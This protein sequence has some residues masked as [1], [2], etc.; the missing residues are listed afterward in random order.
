M[1]AFHQRTSIHHKTSL[2]GGPHGF[3]DPGYMYNCHE[4]L[5]ALYVPDAKSCQA[6]EAATTTGEDCKR[7]PMG[8]G[9]GRRSKRLRYA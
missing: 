6:M 2:H 4:S 7:G 5:D 8:G 1:L 3:P 9:G